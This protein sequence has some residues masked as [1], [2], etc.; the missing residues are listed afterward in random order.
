[1]R[2][3]S[4]SARVASRGGQGGAGGDPKID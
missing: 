4:R 2:A 1:V 3:E